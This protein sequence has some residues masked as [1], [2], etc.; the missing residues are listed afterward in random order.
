MRAEPAGEG[1]GGAVD[2]V[3][4]SKDVC[5]EGQAD[6]DG[7]N[8]GGGHVGDS[9]PSSGKVSYIVNSKPVEII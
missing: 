4:I 8:A 1:E 9:A 5:A 7:Q 3:L 2:D 6:G